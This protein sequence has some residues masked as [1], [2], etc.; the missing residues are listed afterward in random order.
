MRSPPTPLPAA[1]GGAAGKQHDRPRECRRALPTASCPPLAPNGMLYIGSVW[2]GWNSASTQPGVALPAANPRQVR[3]PLI[4]TVACMRATVAG[5]P[6]Q[7]QGVV[8]LCAVYQ[9][10]GWAPTT[11]AQ[12]LVWVM[13]TVTA[14]M[15]CESIV[16][17]DCAGRCKD[18]HHNDVELTT[19]A[20]AYVPRWLYIS[21]R[22]PTS[23]H[24]QFVFLAATQSTSRCT[25]LIG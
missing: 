5:A 20:K 13:S 16:V 10:A 22:P 19:L 7:P 9:D 4:H 25:L 21:V 15:L 14:G 2:L 24:R 18:S 17:A 6:L 8:T 1:A 11:F 23:S 12:M 3:L